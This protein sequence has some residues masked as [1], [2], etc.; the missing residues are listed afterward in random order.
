MAGWRG[1]DDKSLRRMRKVIEQK[2]K[3]KREKRRL[4][5][6]GEEPEED[7]GSDDSI[8]YPNNWEENHNSK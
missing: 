2:R 8:N 4:Y 5:I 7:T 1:D 3:Q 6:Y